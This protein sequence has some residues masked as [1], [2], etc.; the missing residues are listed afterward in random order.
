VRYR[1]VERGG[2]PRNTE[3]LWGARG[4][5]KF[6]EHCFRGSICIFML[7]KETKTYIFVL[8]EAFE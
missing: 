2:G 7:I 5:E 6:E 3:R 4:A 1:E 8:P